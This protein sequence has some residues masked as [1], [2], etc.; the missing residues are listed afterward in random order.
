MPKTY[1]DVKSCDKRI[2]V[3]QGGTRSGKTYSILTALIELC[4]RNEDVNMSIAICRKT[5]PALR[6]TAM[7]DFFEILHKEAIYSEKYHNKSDSTYLLFGN[8]VE[9]FSVDESQKV[10]GR[11]RDFLFLNEANEFAFEDW[12]QLVL[13]T[14]EKVIMDYNPSDE[15]HWIYDSVL[16]REDCQFYKSTYLDNPFLSEVQVKEIELLKETDEYYW[17]VYGLGERGQSREIIFQTHS[18]KERPAGAKLIAYGLDWGYT[19]DPTALAAVYQD[20]ES[21]YIEEEMYLKGLT[22]SQIAAMLR[23]KGI[24]RQVEIIA[25]SA[26][27]KSIDEIHRMG[28]NIKPAVKGADSVRVGIDI[29]R[30]HKIFI[31]EQSQNAMK[32]FRNY[33]WQVDKNGRILETPVDAWNHIVDAVRYVCLKKLAYKKGTYAIR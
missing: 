29:M 8:R 14:T 15:Y 7:R 17:Q 4:A 27:P 33:K 25:D 5:Y 30:R 24:P 2:Q 3:H 22:N 16:V 6:A 12:Q 20:G 19:N 10:R 23:D 11:K 13:R 26:E 21:I 28:F 1:Y 18:Y 31:H 9:F 32:E